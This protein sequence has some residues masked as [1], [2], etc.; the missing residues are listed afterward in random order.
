MLSLRRCLFVAA[1]TALN[2]AAEAAKDTEKPNV[3]FIAID[4]LND[5]VG[6]MGG[7]PQAQ[8][9]NIDRLAARGV[10]FKNAH[11]AVPICNGSRTALLTGLRPWTSGVY[12]NGHDWRAIAGDQKTGQKI[13]TLNEHFRANGYETLGAGKIYHET[14]PRHEDWDE[15][16][17]DAHGADTPKPKKKAGTIEFGATPGDDRNFG[18]AQNADYCIAQLGKPHSKPFFLAYG[19]HKPHLSWIVPQKYFDQFPLETI[20]LPKV[21]DNDLDDVPAFARFLAKP[22]EHAAVVKSGLW[23]DAV[24]AY[25]AAGAFADAMVGRLIDALDRSEFK[26]NTIVVVWGDHGFN[27][28]EKQH[29]SK[30]VLWERSTRSPLVFVVPGVTRSGSECVRTVDFMSVYPT[31]CELCDLQTPS[32]VEGVSIKPLLAD[33]QA[34]WDR[35]AITTRGPGNHSVRTE[36]WRYTRYEDGGDELY[37]EVND[38]N[39]WT[40][41]AS[42]PEHADI[43]SE[44]AR[45]MPTQEVDAVKAPKTPEQIAKNLAK[46]KKQNKKKQN[47]KKQ[48]AAIP[49]KEAK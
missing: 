28:G 25:L 8:T 17:S 7:N 19:I 38:P 49:A 43:K 20:Q 22:D 10:V 4:D 39:E 46:K 40:N 23:K 44:L 11:C 48:A 3:L 33:P 12:G 9:P 16:G 26:E 1:F 5:W 32:H 31:L 45:W 2:S 36:Q 21:L 18:D 13:V 15:Y 14:F 6:C 42:K 41:L 37:D 27:L 24:Q 30:N 35:P 34:A 47:A 29:W